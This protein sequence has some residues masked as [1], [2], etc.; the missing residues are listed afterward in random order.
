MITYVCQSR[1]QL[2][3]PFRYSVAYTQRDTPTC[4][5]ELRNSEN[6]SLFQNDVF[7]NIII[8]IILIFF[9]YGASSGC[10]NRLRK[11]S[12]HKILSFESLLA[13]IIH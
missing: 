1:S 3:S 7:I 4:I 11:E 6:V 5:Y 8:I 12:E 2:N 9:L 10:K 13:I